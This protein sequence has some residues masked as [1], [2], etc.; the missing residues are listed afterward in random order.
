MAFRTAGM[1]WAGPLWMLSSWSLASTSLT[2]RP[3]TFSLASGPR[4]TT[5]L[6]A[7]LTSSMVSY[8]YWM[9]LVRSK[10]M[11][12]PSMAMRDRD[13]SLFIPSSCR[14][15]ASCF[16]SLMRSPEC[17]SPSWM[18]L[19][20]DSS[21]GS[22]WNTKRLCLLGDLPSKG[23]EGRSTA[24]RYTTMGSEAV[25]GT[26]CSFSM[27]Y[28]V[29][30]RC[31]SPMPAIRCSPVSVLMSIWMDGSALL[32]DRSTSMSLGRSAVFFASMATVTTG[33]E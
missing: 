4:S 5:S 14:S 11:L 2:L 20:T 12:Y 21:R 8:R 29:I 9:P 10:S 3:M 7:S 30:S 26:P 32:M 13:S 6:K 19:T 24:S 23:G 27:R 25:M 31:S 1:T 28:W 15:R 22:T 33:S 18:A 16:L 17:I